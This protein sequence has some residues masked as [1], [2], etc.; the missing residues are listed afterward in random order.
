MIISKFTALGLNDV[1]YREEECK[2]DRVSPLLISR[3]RLP[4]TD[5]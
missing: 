1:R 4:N 5:S 3:N 2:K